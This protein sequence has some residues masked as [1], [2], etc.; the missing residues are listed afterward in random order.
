MVCTQ[1][2]HQL[3]DEP[4]GEAAERAVREVKEAAGVDAGGDDAMARAWK[5][6]RGWYKRTFTMD[7]ADEGPIVD[8]EPP[9]RRDD[10]DR[11]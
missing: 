9:K 6:A 5:E 4:T 1:C 2:G 11:G 8:G 3:V 10:E 7:G